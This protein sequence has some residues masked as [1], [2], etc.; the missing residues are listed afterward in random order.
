MQKIGTSLVGQGGYLQLERIDYFALIARYFFR[1]QVIPYF[2][3]LDLG[4]CRMG[5]ECKE[6]CTRIDPTSNNTK[7]YT[8]DDPNIQ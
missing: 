3:E 4:E 2:R 8:Y 1:R 7:V 5:Y 6:A